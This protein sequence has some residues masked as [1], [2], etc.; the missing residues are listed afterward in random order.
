[1]DRVF[2]D[3]GFGEFADSPELIAHKLYLNYEPAA[4]FC[5][6]YT[7]RSRAH[8]Y[9]SQTRFQ[10]TVYENLPQVRMLE[11]LNFKMSNSIFLN[12]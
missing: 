12:N 8:D 9:E 11:E 6:Y 1:M 2:L 10:G 5:V 4:Y 3:R 7:I